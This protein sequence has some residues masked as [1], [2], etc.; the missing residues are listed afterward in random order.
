MAEV[1]WFF[2]DFP[3]MFINI[4]SLKLPYPLKIHPGKGDSG[5]SYWKASFLGAM[6]VSGRVDFPPFSCRAWVF[7]E[8]WSCFILPVVKNTSMIHRVSL[9]LESFFKH[10]VDRRN[11]APLNRYSFSHAGSV[12]PRW[13]MISWIKGICTPKGDESQWL[14][15]DLEDSGAL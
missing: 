2:L 11:P 12:H 7:D 15:C 6:L 5:D 3:E 8:P 4:P 1:S 9:H 10:P 13:C 14:P